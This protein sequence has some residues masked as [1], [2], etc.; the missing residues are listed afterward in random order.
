MKTGRQVRPVR[1]VSLLYTL[2]SSRYEGFVHW[3]CS[4]LILVGSQYCRS[5]VF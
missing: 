3:R 1:R 5:Y 2:S 4:A